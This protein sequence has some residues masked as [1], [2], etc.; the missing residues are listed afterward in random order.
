MKRSVYV[1]QHDLTDCGAACLA[2]VAAHYGLHMPIS[3]IRQMA[4]T[5]QR[6]TNLLGMVEAAQKL[7]FQAKAVRGSRESIPHIPRPSIAHMNMPGGLQH[8]V[9]IYKITDRKIILMDPATGRVETRPIKEFEE[10]WSGVL[11]LLTPDSGFSPGN[12][13]KSIPSRFLQLIH[14]HRK[15]I[16]QA[17]AGAVLYSLLGLSTSLYVQ[18]IIDFVLV[19]NNLGMLRMMSLLMLFI[20]GARFCIGI[21]KNIFIL[22]TGQ[23]IDAGL[24]ISYYAHL[25]K[26]PQ[27]FFDRMKTGE[28]ISRVNDAV[29]IRLFINDLAFKIL[30]NLL[31]LVLTITVISVISWRMVLI[32]LC[33]LP[34]YGLMYVI[35]NKINKRYMRYIM[36]NSARLESHFVESIGQNRTVKLQ[37][38][39]NYVCNKTEI[40]FAGLLD[41]LYKAGKTAVFSNEISIFLSAL[42][43][44]VL[45]WVGSVFALNQEL[46]PGQLMSVYTLSAYMIQPLNQL[47]Q[48]NRSIQEAV[49]AADRLFQI[50][51]LEGEVPGK[52]MIRLDRSMLGDINFQDVCFR[53]GTREFLLSNFNCL[54]PLGQITSLIGESGSGK[55]TLVNLIQKLYRINSGRILI[56]STNIEY[57]HPGSIRK[58]IAVVQQKTELFSGTILENITSFG[59]RTDMNRFFR[60]SEQLSLNELFEH[61]P[62]GMNTMLRENGDGLSG[63]EKQKI[64][65]ARALYSE[66][67]ILVLD[68]ATSSMDAVSE[69]NAL[70]TVRE[71]AKGSGTVI[72]ISHQV[73]N[74]AMADQVIVLDR[75]IVSE[76]GRHDDL[77]KASGTYSRLCRLQGYY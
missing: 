48:A 62:E 42:G 11:I 4:S 38:L 41:H 32:I 49:I 20:I 9:V 35:I 51:D 26:L 29:K 2:S 33:L 30:L 3:R 40:K 31:V 55:S 60:I 28:L 56:G 57:I 65:L 13:K 67:A 36:E 27:Q 75:G 71:F 59:T 46:T 12:H 39:E 19:D 73:R 16:I 44:V 53:Y 23:R 6:G 14:P 63:G 17:G 69:A 45:F 34:A 58:Q 50:I 37:S 70:G 5:D 18:K 52:P 24:V 66:P 74:T 76:S 22:K 43:T 1:K 77:K 54:I 10:T 7:G 47:L 72:M 64:A 68:E 61:F 21:F 8:F 25:M 15:I